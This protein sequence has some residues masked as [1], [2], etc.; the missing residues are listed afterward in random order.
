MQDGN[1]RL[2]GPLLAALT[3]VSWVE[4]LYDISPFATG[5]KFVARPQEIC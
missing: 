3:R 1:G 5:K 4:I 2:A